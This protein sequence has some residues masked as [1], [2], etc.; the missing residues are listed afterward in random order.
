MKNAGRFDNTGTP[1]PGQSEGREAILSAAADC[2]MASGYGGASIDDVARRLRATKGMI[3][4]YFSSKTDLFFE[5]HRRGMAINLGTIEPLSA[6]PEPAETRLARMC[7]AHLANMLRYLNFQRV[8]MMGVEMHLSGPT[9]PE[10][11]EMLNL[12]M[13]E[14]ERYEKLFRK[15]LEEGRQTGRFHYTNAS[16]ASKALLAILNN[17]VLWYRPRTDEA[18]DVQRAIIEEF[19]SFAMR[20]IGASGW[21]ETEQET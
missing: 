10:Q 20:S 5:V 19:Q 4:H 16:L 6:G 21:M 15:V 12:L 1:E 14:R 13:Q 3:Y 9:T 11:R 7:K 17:P 2:F 8:V 18:E